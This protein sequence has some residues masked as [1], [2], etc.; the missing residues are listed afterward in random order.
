MKERVAPT[1]IY[2]SD[3]DEW[4][5]LSKIYFSSNIAKSN[6]K[7]SSA[8]DMF[9]ILSLGAE[10]GMS[11][12]QTVQNIAV[13]N[14]RMTVWGDLLLA[15][16]YGSGKLKSIEEKII[17]ES[18][19]NMRAVCKV[20]RNDGLIGEDGLESVFSMKDA[21]RANLYP[22]KSSYSP[23]KSYPSRMLQMRARSFALRDAFA[24]V[25]K[26]VIAREEAQDYITKNNKHTAKKI[27]TN[28]FEKV[29]SSDKLIGDGSIYLKKVER[30]F[31]AIIKF[32][33]F[34]KL[35]GRGCP[36]TY[37]VAS[38]VKNNIAPINALANRCIGLYSTEYKKSISE[39]CV[40]LNSMSGRKKA[41]GFLMDTISKSPRYIALCNEINV[42]ILKDKAEKEVPHG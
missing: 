1:M 26:G 33:L 32:D 36:L 35:K 27:E 25:L 31:R 40:F 21:K 38:T 5:K 30:R 3:Y 39:T 13:I 16:V 10:L 23:W 6:T 17:D 8:S 37:H 29:H 24:D 2:P 12:A 11:P 20:N 15:I 7:A 34:K 9:L 19:E 28:D 41:L 22:P 4:F 42:S 18:T 14:G